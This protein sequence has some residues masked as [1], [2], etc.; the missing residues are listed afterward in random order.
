[1]AELRFYIPL[2]TKQVILETFFRASPWLSTEKLNLTQQSKHASVTKCTTTQNKHQK[3]LKPGLVTS[4][5]LRPGNGTGPSLL[6]EI[7][8]NMPGST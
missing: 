4:Y 3:K 2:A 5:D 6:K 7:S 1:M 8:V